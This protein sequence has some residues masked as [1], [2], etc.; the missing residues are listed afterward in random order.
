MNKLLLLILVLVGVVFILIL[1]QDQ[2]GCSGEGRDEC[3]LN[4]VE[5]GDVDEEICTEI[6]TI[7][8]RDLCY[9]TLAQKKGESGAELCS[10]LSL[11]GTLSQDYCFYSL[12]LTERELSLCAR[13]SSE[14]QRRLCTKS[15]TLEQN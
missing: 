14:E 8:N 7:E 12:A 13:I 10:K 5:S 2:Y 6:S 4:K 3:L 15:L 11:N 1:V 9:F